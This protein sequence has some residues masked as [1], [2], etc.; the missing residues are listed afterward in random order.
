MNRLLHQ[1]VTRA[2]ERAPDRLAVVSGDEKLTYGELEAASNRLARMLR[3]QGCKRG[4]RVCF[5]IPKSPG[6]LVAILAII[7]ADCIYTPIDPASPAPRAAKILDACSNRWILYTDHATPLLDSIFADPR[8]CESLAAGRMAH[9]RVSGTHMTPLFSLDE[10]D[11][12]PAGPIESQNGPE[13]PAYLL[14]TSGSTGAPK[15]VVIT[16]ANVTAFIDWARSY[17]E[18]QAEDRISG[19]IPLTFD[20][21][22]FDI[23]GAFSAG[24][25]L[26]LVPPHLNMFPHKLAE[27]IRSSALTQWF[28]VPSTLNL[29]A[30]FDVVRNGD[31]PS[32][33]RVLWCGEVFPTPALMYWMKRLP[34]VKFT[35]L[36]G[37][38]ETTIA[39]SYYTVPKCP[40]DEKADIPIGSPCAGESLLVLDESMHPVPQGEI[41][42]L[43]IGGAGLSPGYWNDPQKTSEVFVRNTSGI[44]PHE[45]IYK[46]GDL[47]R[48]GPDGLVTF[49]G[50][51]DSQIKSRGYR[52]ELGEIETALNA[53]PDL[54]EG[55][56]VAVRGDGFEGTTICCAFVPRDG[57]TITP[58]LLR[59]K[60]GET[61]P[62]YMLPARWMQFSVLPKTSNGKIDRVKLKETFV[63]GPLAPASVPSQ[64]KQ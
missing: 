7:K 2:A 58:I 62:E 36:Y 9:G 33:K 24:A 46:T 49:V 16:H 6:A 45:R 37:P 63:T 60:L 52:I 32:L 53:I 30:K 34:G 51:T 18:M 27:F 15:G 64:S 1:W 31:F 8:R 50:R 57:S 19:H 48:V 13:D 12:L 39:S 3:D 17:F 55:A 20:L 41:G 38:T 26:H 42:D 14:F 59:K 21:S 44:G 43:Y 10:V 35:N 22:V 25:E 23:F 56:I 11:S 47:A 61:L 4:D 5:V 40:V 54:G 29:M 28:S